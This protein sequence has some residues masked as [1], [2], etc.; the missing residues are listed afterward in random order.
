MAI[1]SASEKLR[2]IQI[3]PA[4]ADELRAVDT[5]KPGDYEV[6]FQRTNDL[7]DESLEVFMRSSRS[8]MGV[9]G[10][11]M[12][13]LFTAQ[14]DLVNG[15]AGTYLH[16]I[17][18]PIIIKYILQNYED[19]PGIADG[20]LWFANDALYG[21]I[22]NPD[23][24]V[25]M[26]V[27]H[28][29]KLIAWCGAASHESETGASEPGGMPIGADSRFMEGLNLP[30]VKIG[31]N[32]ELRK[33]W[34]EVFNAF[35]IR[36]PQ[37][38][39]TD[40]KA[41]CTAAD[42][43][44]TRVLEMAEKEGQDFVV[45]LFR[46]MLIVAEEGARKRISSWPDGIFRAVAFA[47]AVGIDM[48]LV[49]AANLT[50]TKR[51]DELILDFEG[52][53]P[54]SASP[55]NAHI[56]AVVGHLS[57]YFYSYLFFDLPISSAT[58]APIE[59]RAPE[60][61]LLN[62]S[63]RAGTSCSVMICTGVMSAAPNAFAKMIFST[64][65][66]DRVSAAAANAGNGHIIAGNS[67]WGLP[68][69]DNI[70]YTL[71]TDGQG[72]RPT[73]PG[74]HA[75]HFGHCPFGRA[76]NIEL[77]ENEFPMIIPLSQ[78]QTDSCGFGAQRGGAAVVQLWVAHQAPEVQ[79]LCNSNNSKLTTTQ[80]LFGGYGPAVQPGISVRG[81][82]IMQRMR[83]ESG[84]LTLDFESLLQ[85]GQINGTWEN[86]FLGRTVRSYDEGDVITFALSGGG[87]G[88]GDPLDSDPEAVVRDIIDG[89]VSEWAADNIYRIVWDRERERVEVAATDELRA[90]ERE[91][92]KARGKTWD[93]FQAEWS[94]KRPAEEILHHYGS[95]PDG[96]P[97]TAGLAAA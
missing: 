93:E 88:Y 94:T 43:A 73:Q 6:G 81:A 85:G 86:E 91:A 40:L 92:R 54:E 25:L 38:M 17:V 44:R 68:F 24:V 19:S 59:V 82:D 23:M 3:E 56:Q 66:W 60:G 58:F 52:T 84:A 95:W 64:Q 27:F 35:G 76:P 10:D 51:D 61:S 31:E 77:I 47:D 41:R 33:D 9:A 53:S 30:P 15:A 16:A 96:A 74:M 45:G 48:G 7:V 70:A 29:G 89:T 14:G 46:K 63:D 11:A 71:N 22:H 67:Q 49:R 8:T 42:R 5:L 57:N 36:A 80:P 20:D 18:Q 72:G 55:S 4:T 1:P 62:P 78:H 12:V 2:M 69:A 65:D 50:V 97:V 87:P 37:M 34:L 90:A 75:A 21:G 13:A 26:P 39:I 32:F 83:D 28:E 79:F